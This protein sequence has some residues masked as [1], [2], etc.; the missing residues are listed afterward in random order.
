MK[1]TPLISAVAILT[2]FATGQR[3][4]AAT[5]C[6][7]TVL[8][9]TSVVIDEDKITIKA[10]ANIKMVIILPKG[11]SDGRPFGFAG[12]ETV[13]IGMKADERRAN[14]GERRWRRHVTYRRYLQH[15]PAWCI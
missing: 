3:C 5:D 15:V 7:V 13:W 8:K 6:D 1:S 2:C 9:A 4:G 12:R 11:E 10:E 14:V